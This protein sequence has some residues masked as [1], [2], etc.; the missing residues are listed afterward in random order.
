MQETP[1]Y[2]VVC[3]GSIQHIGHA[4]YPPST[5]NYYLE[6]LPA[7]VSVHLPCCNHQFRTCL[8]PV[9]NPRSCSLREFSPK[10]PFLLGDIF[11]LITFV[12]HRVGYIL[13][14]LIDTTLHAH[15]TRTLPLLTH[16][17][18]TPVLMA[19]LHLQ[20]TD[21]LY[22]FLTT[23]YLGLATIDTLTP[24]PLLLGYTPL[25]V[26]HTPSLSISQELKNG[27]LIPSRGTKCQ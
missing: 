4:A 20:S 27:L 17:F 25:P 11:C 3:V 24:L 10:T 23:P 12:A 9:Y 8:L 6:S 26:V 16:M 13:P 22:T 7:P 2:C 15:R 5:Y 1:P 14:L 21:I 18:M 19:L